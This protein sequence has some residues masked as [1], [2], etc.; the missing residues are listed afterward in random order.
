MYEDYFR[1]KRKPF[2]IAPDPS[3]LYLSERH[4]EAL[5]HLMYGL[6]TDGGFVLITGEVGTGKTTL[7]RSLIDTVPAD[8]DVAFILNPR[9]TVSELLETL[10]E[11][12]GIP[13]ENDEPKTNKHQIDRLNRHLLRTHALDRSTVVI[14]DE[15]QNLSSAVLE[16]I[17]LL[18]NLETNERKL[19][20][21][22]LL[23]QPELADLLDRKEMRQLS[24]RITARYHLAALGQDDTRAYV[25]HRLTLVGGNPLLFTRGANRA[26]FELSRGIPRLINVIADRALLGAYVEGKATVTARIVRKAAREAFG[27]Q[28]WPQPRLWVAAAALLA[29][30]MG[31]AW[32]FW[33]GA[34]T[35][36]A[37]RKIVSNADGNAFI[38]S[39]P[40]DVAP[41]GVIANV[42]PDLES[43]VHP[44]PT[45][46]GPPASAIV[47]TE[48]APIAEA[49]AAPTVAAAIDWLARPAHTPAFELQRDAYAAVFDRWKVPFDGEGVPCNQA[50]QVGLQ[51]LKLNGTLN[52]VQ[53]LD[54][55]AVLELWDE[56]A[57]PYY[58]AVLGH[59]DAG[60]TIRLGGQTFDV[61][62]EALTGHWYGT[63]VVLW[64]MPPDYRGN[65]QMGNSGTTVAWLRQHLA[66]ALRIDLRTA[67]PDQFDQGLQTALVRFQREHGLVPDGV[68]GPITWIAVNQLLPETAGRLNAG[69]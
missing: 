19:L 21:I 11:E 57:D 7:I 3:F 60:F 4:R 64:R 26:L 14:I 67:E 69:S 5:A 53:R 37:A 8:L 2:S 32:A 10:C 18:T 12:L 20:R 34:P 46:A 39:V 65:L 24:Q 49:D 22:I 59:H 58:A 6:Q 28:S 42:V 36:N 48:P 47:N 63:Y 25:S 40:P 54:Y 13:A 56:L 45:V 30:T 44:T 50:P 41:A 35:W 38:S 62:A 29:I 15:A 33:D 9:L 61:A 55:V 68:A 43:G 52:E 31:A 16:Q 51:C 1:I 66:A 17:R 27:R 23:G